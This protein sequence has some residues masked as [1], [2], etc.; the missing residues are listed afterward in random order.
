MR[1]GFTLHELLVVVGIVGILVA[2]VG[3]SSSEIMRRVSAAK[4]LSNLR[5]VGTA[6]SLYGADNNGTYPAANP[7]SIPESNW[8]GD[9]F[10]PR[11]NGLES[12][13]AAYGGGLEAWRKITVCPVNITPAGNFQYVVNYN[14][15]I[16]S[17]VTSPV[18]AASFE[19]KSQIVVMA[20]AT[21]NK[22][23]W[24]AG[25]WG[26][27]SGW[28]RLAN[29]HGETANILWADFHVSTANKDDLVQG[30]FK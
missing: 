11:T 13:P 4:C 8:S 27:S 9:W 23:D 20:D 16:P 7:G 3:V 14:V 19:R 10:N 2:L 24:G 12:S 6:F 5:Q 28:K 18:R 22:T 17:G 25:L 1:G 21:I 26:P 15:M 30:N 29:R